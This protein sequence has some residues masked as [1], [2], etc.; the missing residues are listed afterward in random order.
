[1]RGVRETRAAQA[2]RKSP[3]SFARKA[4]SKTK[5]ESAGNLERAGGGKTKQIPKLVPHPSVPTGFTSVQIASTFP[6]RDCRGS[7][8]QY[9]IYSSVANKDELFVRIQNPSAFRC[10]RRVPLKPQPLIGVPRPHDAAGP[11]PKPEVAHW[12]RSRRRRRSWEI[13]QRPQL[14]IALLLTIALGATTLI[15]VQHEGKLPLHSTSHGYRSVS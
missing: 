5:G 15:L 9:F 10:P 8:F 3:Q 1:M 4:G 12:R 14:L 13:M 7:F 11:M 2:P 6:I